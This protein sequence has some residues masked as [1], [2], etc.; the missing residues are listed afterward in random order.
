M[1]ARLASSCSRNGIRAVA[2][3]TICMAVIDSI[4]GAPS[5]QVMDEE[6]SAEKSESMGGNA[7]GVTKWTRFASNFSVKY[8]CLTV[9]INQTRDDLKS[10]HGNMLETPGG[11]AWKHACILRI[12]MKRGKEKYYEKVNDEK[13]QVGW[14]MVARCHKNQA[15][16]QENRT[17]QWRF[18]AV[19]TEEYG[20]IGIDT[21]EEIMRLAPL[22]GVIER[23]G[24][25][26]RHPALPKG[27]ANGQ[28]ALLKFIQSDDALRKTITSE[29]MAALNDP[30]AQAAAA[31]V[32][33]GDMP[34]GLPETVRVGGDND[35]S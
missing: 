9:G 23:A 27:Q 25:W 20:P 5:S 29:V 35:V 26:Y 16:G 1:S 7:K 10:M 33:E 21:V 18:F 13:V 4:G 3:D 34:D 32:I 14:D 6:R 12:E 19:P 2:T 24:A 15:G 28:A 17:A 31:P 30:E 8:E 11:R 22:V